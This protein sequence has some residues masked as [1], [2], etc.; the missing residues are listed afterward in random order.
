MLDRETRTKAWLSEF[1]F[2]GFEDC[3]IGLVVFVLAMVRETRNHSERIF[4]IEVM[5]L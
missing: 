2:V 5:C 3:W 4:W 1:G